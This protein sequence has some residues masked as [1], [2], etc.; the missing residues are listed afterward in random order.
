MK[1]EQEKNGSQFCH[2][3]RETAEKLASHVKEMGYTHVE[4]LPVMEHPLDAL[5]GLP[6]NRLLCPHQ[7]IRD[8]RRF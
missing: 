1:T 3:Y 6:G 4:L 7:P 2:N 8:P 5:L